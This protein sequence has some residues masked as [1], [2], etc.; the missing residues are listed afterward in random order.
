MAMVMTG[1][2]S[3]TTVS[4][5]QL[6]AKMLEY[7]RQ[8]EKTGAPLVVTDNRRPVLKVLP[9]HEKATPEE[10]FADVRRKVKYHEDLLKDTSEE[11]GDLR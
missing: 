5:S 1:V 8:V 3:M 10:V 2:F 6:K 9:Y 11:W 7:F 4:K